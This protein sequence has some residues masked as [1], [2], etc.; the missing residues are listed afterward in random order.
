V[1][2]PRRRTLGPGAWLV[3]WG[4]LSLA[5]GLAHPIAD[6]FHQDAPAVALEEDL[7]APGPHA[8]DDPPPDARGPCLVGQAVPASRPCARGLVPWGAAWIPESPILE[9]CSPVPISV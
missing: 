6:L 5:C 1:T 8:G 4:A 3:L 2:G 7:P 9:T